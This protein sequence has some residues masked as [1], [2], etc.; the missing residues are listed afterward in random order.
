MKSEFDN[1]RNFP[2]IKIH[3]PHLKKYVISW[4]HSHKIRKKWNI[5]TTTKSK[6]YKNEVIIIPTIKLSFHQNTSVIFLRSKSQEKKGN[7]YRP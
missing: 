3:F 1:S 2:R 4:K 5:K 6:L 7:F